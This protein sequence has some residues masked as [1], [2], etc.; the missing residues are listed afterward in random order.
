MI[1]INWAFV[2]IAILLFLAGFFVGGKFPFYISYLMVSMLIISVIYILLIKYFLYI[3]MEIEQTVFNAGDEVECVTMAK[4]PFTLPIPYI[5]IQESSLNYFTNKSAGYLK[6][7]TSDESIWIKNNIKF[8]RRGVYNLGGLY[9]KVTDL[10]GLTSFS[11]NV[12]ANTVVKVYPNIYD[13]ELLPSGGKDIYRSS[14]NIQSSNEDPFSLK[15]VR[16]YRQGDSLKKIHWKLSAKY[17][18]LYIKNSD[19][20]TGEEIEIFVDMRSLNLSYDEYGVTD[21]KI[22]D[23]G[24]SIV[25]YM[26]KRNISVNVFLN[27]SSGIT[28]RIEDKESFGKFVEHL[29]IQD[30]DGAT[31]L[32][33]F[34]HKNYFKLHTMN[35]LAVI[36]AE[37][38]HSLMTNLLSIKNSGYSVTVFYCIKNSESITNVPEL[39]RFGIACIYFDDLMNT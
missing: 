11:A 27:C 28:F 35:G 15:D 36:T 7:I 21:E 34:I 20:I 39:N 9:V 38:N 22:I 6:S 3:A 8:Y 5:T 12:T 31:D 16:K 26:L 17:G 1:K 24:V 23:M 18:N 4:W 10:F 14:I 30:S 13:I 2:I 29:I 32:T 25:N 33:E 19:N 37:I